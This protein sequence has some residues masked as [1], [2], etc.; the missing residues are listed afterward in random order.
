VVKAARAA[1]RPFNSP[2]SRIAAW[3][4]QDLAPDQY[5]GRQ[6]IHWMVAKQW[7][8]AVDNWYREAPN[9]WGDGRW[10]LMKCC[11]TSLFWTPR[12][13]SSK[14]HKPRAKFCCQRWLCPFCY[15]REIVKFLQPFATRKF[16]VYSDMLTGLSAESVWSQ[17]AGISDTLKHE[18]GALA[19]WRYV[20]KLA[21]TGMWV[22]RGAWLFPG[23]NSI[24][25]LE[26]V[27]IEALA[28]PYPILTDT[29]EYLTPYL[30]FM[31]K[32]RGREVSGYYRTVKKKEAR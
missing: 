16:Q 23:R 18:H 4:L 1:R 26:S 24:I 7:R 28:Y 10:N 3:A 6:E 25:D 17:F 19:S 27:L 29:L 15:S 9:F 30:T 5:A 20:Y 21:L 2:V 13:V 14:G 11:N 31:A 12:L 32:H 8:T 22:G